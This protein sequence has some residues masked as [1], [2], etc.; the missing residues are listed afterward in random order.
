VT[1]TV[2]TQTLP[3]T[4]VETVATKV[5]VPEKKEETSHDALP[6]TGS[7]L[8]N[9]LGRFPSA[10]CLGELD[11][12]KF[13]AKILSARAS[14]TN[15]SGQSAGGGTVEPIFKKLADEIRTLQTSVS[16]HDQFAKSS[17][18]CYQRVMLDLVVELEAVR[19]EQDARIRKIEEELSRGTQWTAIFQGI[20]TAVVYGVSSTLELL[21]SSLICFTPVVYG[22]SSSTLELLVS[23]L[24]FHEGKTFLDCV[25]WAV[26]LVCTVFVYRVMISTSIRKKKL[27]A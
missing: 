10:A 23:S 2:P 8:A 11:F 21:V 13:K 4:G 15:G 12:A 19:V 17:I 20:Y 25:Q 6:E 9:V 26:G 24:I 22:V 16:V 3:A 18:A 5:P 14:N 7:A 27:P 1:V